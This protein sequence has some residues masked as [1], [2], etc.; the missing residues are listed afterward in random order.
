MR[1]RLLEE[2]RLKIVMVV[3]LVVIVF[4][5]FGW[6]QNEGDTLWTRTYGDTSNQMANSVVQTSDGGFAVA[7][8]SGSSNAADFWLL[9]IDSDG[10]TLWTRKYG[11][12]DNE[13]ACSV[14][15][16]HDGG[17]IMAGWVL[18]DTSGF[19]VYNLYVVRAD[20]N[21]D[22]LWTWRYGGHDYAYAY[23]IEETPDSGF[24][25]I[26]KTGQVLMDYDVYLV[27]LDSD[28]DTLWT[29]V[30]GGPDNQEGYDVELTP[31]G[32][33]ILTGETGDCPDF[34]AYLIKVDADGDSIWGQIYGDSL[35][36]I[37]YSVKPTID[38]GYIVAGCSEETTPGTLK[39][40]F[41]KTNSIGD[42]IW[43][44]TY[45]GPLVNEANSI[46][47][48]FSGDYIATG[49]YG[50]DRETDLYILKLDINGDTLWTR[51]YGG[52]MF[53][54]GSSVIQAADASFMVAGRT[55]SF[56]AGMFDVYIL[57]IAGPTLY[58]SIDGYITDDVERAPIEN[59]HVVAGQSEC[60]SAPDGYY[61]L[62]DLPV[63]LYDVSFSHPGYRDTV[64][65]GVAVTPGNTTELDVQMS[66]PGCDYAVGDVNGSSNY[67]GLDITYGVAFLKGGSEPLCDLCPLCPDWFYCGDVNGSCNYNGLDITYGVA[68]FK[69]GADPIPC[70]E[71]PPA[72]LTRIARNKNLKNRAAALPGN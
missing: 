19:W 71:C 53:D 24:V 10:D 37:G 14:K 5:S 16:T 47:E 9:R 31:D 49:Y 58:G 45:G 18:E 63:E 8:M 66:S 48:T 67:N 65:T 69:G 29:R 41:I 1:L 38:G 22:T 4:S 15:Q 35:I 64:V 61:D 52:A 12:A 3:C 44:R 2:T 40:Y 51:R 68:Y 7:G 39:T 60:W 26:G 59:V 27:K 46:Y 54:H 13:E 70:G 57:K 55:E 21:G 34:N 43:T 56:G 28:G 25:L 11:T 36:D 30:Y 33:Y 6:A 72:G 23:D 62:R 17:Y 32:G 42:T 50:N 20:A